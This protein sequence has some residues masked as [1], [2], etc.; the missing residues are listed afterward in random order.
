MTVLPAIV[1]KMFRLITFQEALATTIQGYRLVG[2]GNP[3][4]ESCFEGKS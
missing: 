1:Y 4:F 3:S 2:E